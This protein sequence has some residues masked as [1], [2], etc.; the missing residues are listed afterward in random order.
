[1]K[2]KLLVVAIAVVL[3]G[4]S[5]LVEAQTTYTF[6]TLDDPL[7]SSVYY[8]TEAF[9]INDKSQIIG[10]YFD[11]TISNGYHHSQGFIYSAGTY[12]NLVD[13]SSSGFYYGTIPSAISD[14]GQVVGNYFTPNGPG[15]YGF[16]L[17]GGIYTTI[18]DPTALTQNMATYFK[19]INN[20]GEMVGYYY[21]AASGTPSHGFLY[22]HGIYTTLDD[23]LGVGSTIATGIRAVRRSAKDNHRA[24][25]SLIEIRGAAARCASQVCVGS[26]DRRRLQSS[27]S[28][29]RPERR[30]GGFPTAKL[31]AIRCQPTTHLGTLNALD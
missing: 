15:N 11:D 25:H 28:P 8:G 18:D 14:K 23:P 26:G 10:N 5:S 24:L 1:M 3:L 27:L 31:F 7:A 21:D 19:G 20:K 30:L 4:R 17:S 22:N 29:E 6:T 12:T 9:G 2:T 13:P 16:L